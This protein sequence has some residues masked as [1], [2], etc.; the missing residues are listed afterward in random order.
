MLADHHREALARSGIDLERAASRGYATVTDK[1]YLAEMKITS[2]GRNIPG[3]LVPLLDVRGS[4]WGYQFRSDVPRMS[5]SG[6]RLVKYETP[7]GQRSGLD[8]P[9][10]A[11]EQLGDPSVPLWITEGS[12]KADCAVA[13]GLCCVALAG[14]WNWR[15]TN[16]LGGKVAL[17]DWN[18]VA[19]NDR[20][21]IIAYDGDVA[22]KKTVRDAM[23]ALGRYL[24]IK[25]AHVE[26]LHLPDGDAKTG[27][28]DFLVAHPIE[29]LWQLVKPI[30]PQLR[31]D[32]RDHRQVEPET[33]PPA[34]GSIDGA[35]LL[36]DVRTWFARFICVVDTGDLEILAL[37]VAHTYLARE[38]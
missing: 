8:V 4:V 33:E 6:D 38:L 13:Q 27:L 5:S 24:S 20:R 31:Q 17:P 37:W 22:S 26:F 19:L 3:L 16:G 30:T 32:T 12:K 14:V 11:G 1:R 9:R 21:V 36:D 34:F 2:A 7:T 28:D 15:G 25:G 29:E 23:E 10:G 18:D 35:E